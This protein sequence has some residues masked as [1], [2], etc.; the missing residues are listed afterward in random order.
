[1]GFEVR[2]DRA[3]QGRKKLLRE[4]E[5]YLALVAQ[6]LSNSQA[7][8]VVGVNP[9][10]GREWRNGRPEGRVK[11]PRPPARKVLVAEASSRFSKIRGRLRLRR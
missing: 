3:P 2:S 4:R 9:R 8:R 10:T 6:G 1:M 7:C 11:R 5:H